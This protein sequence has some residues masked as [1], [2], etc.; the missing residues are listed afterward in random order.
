MADVEIISSSKYKFGRSLLKERVELVLSR[1]E[2]R[3]EV[4]V[5]VSL[6]GRRKITELNE[7]YLKHEGVTDVLSFPLRDPQDEREFV[8]PPNDILYLGEVFI[9]YPVAMEQAFARQVTIEEQL[10]DLLEHGIMHL[11]GFHHE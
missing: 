4:S 3:G 2:V 8:T 1:Y 9:C 5:T 6:V 10:A 7:L 11:L